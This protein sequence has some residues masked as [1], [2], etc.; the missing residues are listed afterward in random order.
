M[1]FI[2]PKKYWDLYDRN[3]KLPRPPRMRHPSRG[4]VDG[5]GRSADGDGLA[6]ILPD[7]GHTPTTQTPGL[8]QDPPPPPT[9]FGATTVTLS[10]NTARWPN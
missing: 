8:R 2:A 1:P 10:V 7:H 3:N 6:R 5:R 4:A 9:L